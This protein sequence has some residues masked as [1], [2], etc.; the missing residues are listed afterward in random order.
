[1]ISLIIFGI[2]V[3]ITYLFSYLCL[4]DT[5]GY[6][7]VTWI[8]AVSII[9]M[10]LINGIVAIICSKIL[11]KKFFNGDQKFYF[12]SKKECKFYDKIGIK[13][14]KDKTL[15]MGFLNGFRKNKV[16]DSPEYIERFIL[17][18]KKGYLTH[19]MSIFVSVASMFILPIKFWLPMCLPI[20]VTSLILNIIPMMILRYNMPRL[21]TMLRFSLRNNK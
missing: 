6:I 21:K 7:H 1:M 17:E 10:I 19:F 5:I 2:G 14:W 12:P 11:P 9:G 4:G 8:A 15:E 3:V 20:V 18:N 13:K 16:E